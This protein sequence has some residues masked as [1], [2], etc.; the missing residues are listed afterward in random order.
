MIGHLWSKRSHKPFLSRE[1]T[2]AWAK[3]LLSVPAV[4]KSIATRTRNTSAGM[5]L[6]ELSV[7]HPARLTGKRTLMSVGDHSVIG[8]AT[9]ALHARL[10]VGSRVVI[11]DNVTILTA[12]HRADSPGWESVAADVVIEDYAWVA[13]GAVLMPG[14]RIGRG[15][16][17]GAF[18]VV[19]SDVP[20][21]H[22]VIGNPAADTGRTRPENLEYDPVMGLAFVRA[23][24]V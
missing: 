11:N 22:I 18:A 8:Q 2:A 14:V 21:Y 16:V 1:W 9:I 19:R 5:Q 10:T 12:S 23:W 6:G 7:V 17:V 3:R 24:L 13:Y 15:A 20:P 4:L